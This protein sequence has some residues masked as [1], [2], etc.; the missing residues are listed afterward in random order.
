MTIRRSTLAPL[1]TFTAKVYICWAM[2]V[3]GNSLGSNQ[4]VTSLAYLGAGEGRKL[5]ES[6]RGGWAIYIRI[7]S[8]LIHLLGIERGGILRVGSEAL[9]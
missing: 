4:T 7:G 6:G 3:S 2:N 9:N 1:V 8:E 5:S